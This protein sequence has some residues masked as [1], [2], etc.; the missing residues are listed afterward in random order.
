MCPSTVREGFLPIYAPRL[1]QKEEPFFRLQVYKRVV[2]S[3]VEVYERGK[4]IC[5]LVILERPLTGN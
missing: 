2:V 1:C 3:Q 4:E 5:H